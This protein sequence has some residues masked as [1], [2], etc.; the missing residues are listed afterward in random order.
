M[1]P[2]SRGPGLVGSAHPRTVILEGVRLCAVCRFVGRRR[3]DAGVWHRGGRRPRSATARNR[4]DVAGAMMAPGYGDSRSAER[5]VAAIWHGLSGRPARP[6]GGCGWA[7]G[8]PR[9]SSGSLAGAVGCRSAGLERVVAD[10]R[11][12]ELARPSGS[13]V[14]GI[15]RRP[16]SQAV[17]RVAACTWA[18][19]RGRRPR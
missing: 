5:A 8:R 12:S 11:W 1:F 4:G 18:R 17:A 19:S 7:E 3:G 2:Y 10:Q 9:P 15:M 6:G 13:F 14:G 16:S